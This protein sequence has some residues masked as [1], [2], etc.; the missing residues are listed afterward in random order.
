M[1]SPRANCKSSET[2][3]AFLNGYTVEKALEITATKNLGIFS[4]CKGLKYVGEQREIE[5]KILIERICAPVVDYYP[6]RLWLAFHCLFPDKDNWA[7]K[8]AV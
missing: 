4:F 2:A 7:C 1:V 3:A 5:V 6:K 8:R